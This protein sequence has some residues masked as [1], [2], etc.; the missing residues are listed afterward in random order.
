MGGPGQLADPHALAARVES[1]PSSTPSDAPETPSRRPLRILLVDDTAVNKRMLVRLLQRS[2]PSHVSLDVVDA[3]NG[4][5][6][7][8][9]LGVA[10]PADASP[11]GSR[12]CRGDSL[13]DVCLLD[14]EMPVLNG[15]NM[16]V[17][18]RGAGCHVPIIGITGNALPEDVQRFLDAGAHAVVPKPVQM[19]QLVAAM[20]ELLPWL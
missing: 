1:T 5:E 4:A 19:S 13:F 14:A 15:Y 8:A 20:R 9:A 6:G 12:E 17:A 11:C 18:A 7:L 2:L 3:T 16:A 10:W